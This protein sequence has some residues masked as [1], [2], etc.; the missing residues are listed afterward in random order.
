MNIGQGYRPCGQCREY[1]PNL[2]GCA[3]WK[4]AVSLAWARK[5]RIADNQRTRHARQKAELD[6]VRLL[7]AM[8]LG[9]RG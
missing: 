3:H 9:A 7:R 8:A 4:P 2:S 6:R 5:Q 1:V